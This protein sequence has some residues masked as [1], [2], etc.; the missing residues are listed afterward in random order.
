MLQRLLMQ[1]VVIV[2][3]LGSGS[4]KAVA[5]YEDIWWDANQSGMGFFIGQQ[6]TRLGIGWFHYGSGGEATY[7]LLAGDLVNGTVSGDLERSTGP[8]PGVGYNAGQVVRVKAGTA[9]VTFNS[10]NSATFS[11]N[12]DGRTGSIPLT[13]MTYADAGIVGGTWPFV[14][15]SNV[16]GCSNPDDNG[17][18]V[19][20]GVLTIGSYSGGQQSTTIRFD[21]DQGDT[22]NVTTTL[23]REGSLITGSGTLT[24]GYQG[25][26]TLTY[27]TWVVEDR[28]MNSEYSIRFAQ[29][30]IDAKFSSIRQ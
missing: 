28:F 18:F 9:S 26:G 4:A 16:T 5:S 29:C 20:S 7:L 23:N 1:W 25:S 3:V 12:Y 11:Y 15:I 6:G 24:C 21:G 13:R 22:C 19:D 27:T 2:L 8:Q 14:A 10:R 30:T 17:V